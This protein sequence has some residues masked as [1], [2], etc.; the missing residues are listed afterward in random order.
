MDVKG[1]KIHCTTSLNFLTFIVFTYNLQHSRTQ[2]CKQ[3]HRVKQDVGKFMQMLLVMYAVIDRVENITE[4]FAATVVL[5][6]SNGAFE[7]GLC[8]HASVSR[9]CNCHTNSDPH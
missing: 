3:Q 8:I 4:L 2:H 5:V 6:S 9:N 1:E 7:G